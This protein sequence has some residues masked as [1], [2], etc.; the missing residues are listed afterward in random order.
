MGN[1]HTQAC[2]GFTPSAQTCRLADG[3]YN[4]NFRSTLPFEVRST[5]GVHLDHLTS[6]ATGG[7]VATALT[8][9]ENGINADMTTIALNNLGDVLTLAE[10][11]PGLVSQLRQ[12]VSRLLNAGPNGAQSTVI[13]STLTQ[14]NSLEAKSLKDVYAGSVASTGVFKVTN[15]PLATLFQNIVKATEKGHEVS[16]DGQ[17][18][19]D[20][21]TGKKYIP[22]EK[23]T[24][25]TSDVNF[26]YSIQVFVTS[27]LAIKKEAPKVY[28]TFS[29]EMRRA[30]AIGGC[31]FAQQYADALLRALDEGLFKDPISLFLMGE[32]NRIYEE[33]WSARK[34]ERHTVKEPS[35]VFQRIKFGPVTTPLGGKGAGVVTDPK[36]KQKIKCNRFHATPQQ[37]CTAGIPKGDPRYGAELVG[38]CAYLH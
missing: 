4:I 25:V 32:H 9:D 5:D 20:V 3:N 16:S 2:T 19:L 12:G 15:Y 37:P 7:G 8:A 11:R 17:E 30:C 21:T 6:Y 22:F 13:S 31:A 36:T 34:S 23:T 38:L 27:V 26:M 24:K 28:Y 18:M 35:D 33:I 14:L 29:K 10:K 1:D